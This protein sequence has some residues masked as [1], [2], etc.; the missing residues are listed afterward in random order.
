MGCVDGFGGTVDIGEMTAGL[1][2][3]LTN[4]GSATGLAIGWGVVV[5]V[6]RLTMNEGAQDG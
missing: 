6:D 1:S 3:G 4:D 5:L 2:M